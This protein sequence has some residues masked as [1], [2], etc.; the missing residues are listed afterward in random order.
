[1]KKQASS[2]AKQ[3]GEPGKRGEGGKDIIQSSR[4]G[5]WGESMEGEGKRGGAN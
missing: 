3:R 4:A 1:M 2:V 5:D